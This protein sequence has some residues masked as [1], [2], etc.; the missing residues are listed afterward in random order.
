MRKVVVS[1]YVTL[2]G[3]FEDPGWS[4]SYWSDEAQLFARDQLW[5]SGALLV[6]RKTYE[7]FAAAWPTDEWIEREGEF[8]E[9]MNSLPKY[10][11]SKTL[12]EPLEWNNSHL[13]EGDVAEEVGKLKEESGQDIL[14]YSSAELMRALMKENLI[15]Q[16]RLWVHP[17]VLGSGM[18]LFPEGTGKT[19]LRLVDTTTL[20]NGVVVLDH[21]LAS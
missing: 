17:L 6:G 2:D 1:T 3:V 14:M 11:A 7:L 21:Q 18:R 12:D 15:D 5:A 4:A 9:R 13:L 20:P 10:V 16:Y 8:A 19:E